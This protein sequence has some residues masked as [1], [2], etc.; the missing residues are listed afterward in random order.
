[1]S[2]PTVSDDA[3]G[4]VLFPEYATL[5]DLVAREVEGLTDEQ[6]DF[7]SDQWPWS[8]WSI[9]HQVSHIAFVIYYWLL[10]IFVEH[11]FPSRRAW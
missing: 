2:Q 11:L 1:M 5:Y 3:P 8:G 4:S 9:R 10:V 6:L 7:R